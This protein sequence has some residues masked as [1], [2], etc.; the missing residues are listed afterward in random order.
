MST[1]IMSTYDEYYVLAHA[2]LHLFLL[3]EG[4]TALVLALQLL[5]SVDGLL[6][7]RQDG[8]DGAWHHA[9]LPTAAR[10][11]PLDAVAV[12]QHLQHSPLLMLISIF[13][14]VQV[15]VT[16]VGCLRCLPALLELNHGLGARNDLVHGGV[17]LAQLL[18][19]VLHFPQ[20]LLAV[21]Q[22]EVRLAVRAVQL[23]VLTDEDILV[24]DFLLEIP[25]L[26]GA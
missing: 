11:A 17:E 1:N 16:A 24:G 20:E 13:L 12:V 26:L 10:Y 18:A 23:L 2:H 15:A 7:G 25:Y 5:G 9:I 21:A 8:E 3:P 22:T 6:V 19:D 4:D 14:W